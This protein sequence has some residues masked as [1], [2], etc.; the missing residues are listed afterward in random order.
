MTAK[1]HGFGSANV[2]QF[3]GFPSVSFL[4]WEKSGRSKALRKP[5]KGCC[6]ALPILAAKPILVNVAEQFCAK[7]I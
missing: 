4:F 6:I 7:L 2:G 3:A 1:L 5:E